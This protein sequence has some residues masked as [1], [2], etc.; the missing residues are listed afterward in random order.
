MIDIFRSI[1]REIL[2][3]L[4]ETNPTLTVSQQPWTAPK[5]TIYN[6]YQPLCESHSFA[7]EQNNH[8][9]ICQSCYQRS[10]F[11]FLLIFPS[12]F[13]TGVVSTVG[14]FQGWHYIAHVTILLEFDLI[15]RTTPEE[16]FFMALTR[17]FFCWWR[18]QQRSHHACN[19]LCS[20]WTLYFFFV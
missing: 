18:T 3:I 7:H 12:H 14:R 15:W 6:N 4:I 1:M 2:S 19:K 8:Q 13:R 5:T 17:S 16:S 20:R 11:D 9:P 10:W